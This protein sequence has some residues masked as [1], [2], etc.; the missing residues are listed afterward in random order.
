M[1]ANGQF[2]INTLQNTNTMKPIT[3][4]ILPKSTTP[5]ITS[6]IIPNF[7]HVP[8]VPNIV[9]RSQISLE[10]KEERRLAKQRE[11][12]NRYRDKTKPY[13]ELAGAP[14]EKDKIIGM[15]KLCYPELANL[16]SSVLEQEVLS[17]IQHITRKRY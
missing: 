13:V 10:E 8:V 17:C 15:F 5:P 9:N 2:P 4:T 12:T 7:N 14:T 1:S 11:R 3:L 16:P 6:T